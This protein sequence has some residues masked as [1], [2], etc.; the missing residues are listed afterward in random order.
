MIDTIHLVYDFKS[1]VEMSNCIEVLKNRYALDANYRE[2]S[3]NSKR[4]TQSFSC[5]DGGFKMWI[6]HNQLHI[7]G[8]LNKLYFND[9]IRQMNRS[10][11]TKAYD[12]LMNRFDIIDW[13]EAVH[14]RIDL[15]VNFII[16]CPP[17]LLTSKLIGCKRMKKAIIKSSAE[18]VIIGNKSQH[19][20]FY[21]KNSEVDVN[22]S[23]SKHK[24]VRKELEDGYSEELSEY[25]LRIEYRIIES[26]PMKKQFNAD[27]VTI[28]HV[29][30]NV[31][32]LPKMWYEMYMNI[33]KDYSTDIN[34]FSNKKEMEMKVIIYYGVER[35]KSLVNE[36]HKA[37]KMTMATK[38]NIQR[39]LNE[40]LVYQKM[41]S[42]PVNV[43]RELDDKVEEFIASKSFMNN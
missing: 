42:D 10:D 26:Y 29:L 28:S 23:K 21:D 6:V 15:G 3:D 11:L 4:P 1:H 24:N 9:N 19:M 43:V 20:I 31:E 5:W 17:N 33:E 14:K 8:S 12:Y 38:Q 16:S 25:L 36:S 7:Q 27:R 35:I 37:K 34:L 30:N 40:I 13:S 22:K 39:S 32:L 2:T 41:N 18:S